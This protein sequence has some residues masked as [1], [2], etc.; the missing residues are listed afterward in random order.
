MQLKQRIITAA[1]AIPAIILTTCYANTL[2]FASLLTGFISLGA[3]EWAD[4]SGWSGKAGKFFY[5]L[6]IFFILIAC[7]IVRNSIVAIVII[8]LAVGL[9]AVLA[10]VIVVQQKRQ[11]LALGNRYIKA[12]LGIVVLAPAWMSM[13]S[14]HNSHHFGAVYVLFLLVLVWLADSAAY[15]AGHFWG[16]TKLA[17]IISPG[18]TWEG[19]LGALAVSACTGVIFALATG[20]Q[21]PDII[22]FS[23]ICIVT[24]A[25]SVVGD[26]TESL[27]K[28]L[29]N[30]KDS[31][32]VF[33]GHGGVMDRI[34]SLTAAAP[35]FLAG[36]WLTRIYHAYTGIK[37]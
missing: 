36:L 20:M 35:I 5:S 29:V 16:K 30:T 9:W 8:T 15:F 26:L 27:M 3:W 28:R 21:R 31:G 37:G 23:I 2:V 33:P 13:V 34:D 32:S 17:T 10:S 14:I 22:I 7:F 4:L 12:L 25:G 24:V 19:V 6:I 11:S 18:K 1:I